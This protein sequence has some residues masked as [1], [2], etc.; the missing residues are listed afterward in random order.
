M[1][2]GKVVCDVVEA[3]LSPDTVMRCLQSWL[4]LIQVTI[5]ENTPLIKSFPLTLKKK[6]LKKHIFYN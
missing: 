6:Q 1:S 4:N 5:S 2:G 3:H